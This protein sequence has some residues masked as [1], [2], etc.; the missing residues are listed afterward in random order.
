MSHP[1]IVA[2][3][4][5]PSEMHGLHGGLGVNR[6]KRFVTE[7]MLHADWDSFEHNRLAPGA[8]IGEHV[9]T[10]AEEIYFIVAGSDREFLNGE[11][12][13]VGLGDLALTSPRAR[14]RPPQVTQ[15]TASAGHMTMDWSR[16]LVDA[17]NV[18]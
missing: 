4:G 12:R 15:P 5:C 2:D 3:T 1:R 17:G 13:D 11:M 7:L 9:Y 6:W 18:G 10:H 14:G 8:A 16:R